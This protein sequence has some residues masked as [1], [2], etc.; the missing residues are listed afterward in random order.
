MRDVQHVRAKHQ[1]LEPASES[2]LPVPRR[3]HVSTATHIDPPL[4][5]GL[6]LR[7]AQGYVLVKA[8]PRI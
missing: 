2:A 8:S 3:F 1:T 5:S 6:R 7:L 4:L